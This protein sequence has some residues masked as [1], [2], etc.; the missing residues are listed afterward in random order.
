MMDRETLLKLIQEDDE[1]LLNVRISPSEVQNSDL[2]LVSRFKEINDFI[3]ETGYEPQANSQDMR[4]FELHRRLNHIRNNQEY[5]SKL[6]NHDEFN[7]LSKSKAIASIDDIFNDDDIGILNDWSDSIFDIKN[8][9]IE[10]TFPDYV[11]QRKQ[12]QNFESYEYLFK[13]CHADLVS[14]K[15][16][17]IR[18]AKEQQIKEGDFF[19][20]KG[21]M[22]Y[23]ASV[24]EKE[25]NNGKTN[26]RLRCIFENGT[27][28]D[29]LLRS[30]ARELYRNGR[31]ITISDDRLLEDLN[32]IT[33]NDKET[34]WIYILRSL[35]QRPEIQ[36]IDQLYKIGFS[37]IPIEERIKNAEQEPTYLMASVSLIASYQC[38]NKTPQKFESLLHRFFSTACLDINVVDKHGRWH[39]PREWF[40]VPLQVINQAIDLLINGDIINCRYDHNQKKI[41]DK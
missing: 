1:G 25:I 23:V 9:P 13:Q 39:S 38:F 29:L 20:L 18:F 26:A 41:V 10:I 4:E 3:H 15:R 24:G 31:R 22:T 36:S 27:E 35:S 37:S 34:G 2:R 14:E 30:L 11:A 7:L 19:I 16:R 33:T 6:Q 8:I 12:C 21:V 17:L 28:S 40:V 5:F 32:S